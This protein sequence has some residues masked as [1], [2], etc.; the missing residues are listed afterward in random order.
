M[1]RNQE[2]ISQNN[3]SLSNDSSFEYLPEVL[4]NVQLLDPLSEKAQQKA[5]RESAFRAKRKLLQKKYVELH[6]EVIA[7]ENEGKE[8]ATFEIGF[9][10]RRITRGGKVENLPQ[11]FARILKACEEFITNPKRFPSLYAWG[12]DGVNNVQCRRLIARVL[13][14]ILTNTD[15]IGGR[16]GQPTEAGIKTISWNQ[17]AEDYALRFGEY[18]SPESV[19]S[20]VRRLKQAAYLHTE[21]INVNVNASEGE[22]RS[23][24]AYKQLSERFFSDLKVVRYPNIVEMILATRTRQEKKG[25]RFAWL[26]FRTLASKVQEIYNANRLNEHAQTNASIFNAYHANP[27]LIPH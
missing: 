24:A 19:A 8:K 27:S 23:A 14:C 1:K 17:I 25:L 6:H 4:N 22:I 15:L 16:I 11:E 10:A 5:V 20:V 13:A 2:H 3:I 26:D 9:K 21:R 12:G 7:R 18:V